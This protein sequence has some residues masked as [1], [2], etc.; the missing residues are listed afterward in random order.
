MTS[1]E[2]FKTLKTI[3]SAF[4]AGQVL[5]ALVI[6]FLVYETMTTS[7]E[8]EFTQILL[9]VFAAISVGSVTTGFILFNQKMEAAQAKSWLNEK[10]A[11]F[12][13][14]MLIKVALM[15]G[16]ALFAIVGLLM[17]ANVYF[18]ALAALLIVL[19]LPGFPTKFHVIEKLRLSHDER[20]VIENPDGVVG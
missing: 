18:F 9:M 11:D 17:T 6:V 2:Y 7:F 4:L 20:K 8:D 19:Q 15:E 13:T 3:Y 1:R 16:P 10:L 5:F 12:R 14:A